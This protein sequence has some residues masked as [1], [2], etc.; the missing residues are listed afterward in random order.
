MM[1]L[2]I[3]R[4]FALSRIKRPI[5]WY[6]FAFFFVW[7]PFG[8]ALMTVRV[9]VMFF[10]LASMYSVADIPYLTKIR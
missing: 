5:G 2:P 3:E 7:T 4:V 10:F 8:I 9:L 1:N 6:H